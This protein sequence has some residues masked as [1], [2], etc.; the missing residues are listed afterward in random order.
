MIFRGEIKSSLSDIE[1]V[2]KYKS[3]GNKQ[4][5]GELFLRYSPLVYG[6]CF[7]YLR[8]TDDSKDV[9]MEIFD[10]LNTLLLNHEIKNFKP[11]LHSVTKNHCLMKLRKKN[12]NR[13]IPIPEDEENE[14]D[15]MEL[16]DFLSYKDK[17]STS[18]FIE[19]ISKI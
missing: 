11:W 17:F 14:T 13:F 8:N 16:P 2:A 9:V 10:R 7:K 4:V 1:L 12:N 6:V 3:S 18:G 19:K 5:L 15:F